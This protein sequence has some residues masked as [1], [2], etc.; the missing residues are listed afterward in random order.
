MKEETTYTICREV[1]KP[2][3]KRGDV[4]YTKKV[5]K[6]YFLR[7]LS[8]KNGNLVDAVWIDG[9]DIPISKLHEVVATWTNYPKATVRKLGE[10][11]LEHYSTQAETEFFVEQ[12]TTFKIKPYEQED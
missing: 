10:V 3:P 6:Q 1:V 7:F 8:D 12:T 4:G 2:E 11:H 9:N 5:I